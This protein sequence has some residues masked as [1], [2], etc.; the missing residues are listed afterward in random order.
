MEVIKRVAFRDLETPPDRRVGIQQ[1]ALELI[2]VFE[3]PSPGNA[4]FLD[5]L[6]FAMPMQDFYCPLVR[7]NQTFIFFVWF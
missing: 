6:F 7:A 2:D 5:G 3:R 1:N 4:Q